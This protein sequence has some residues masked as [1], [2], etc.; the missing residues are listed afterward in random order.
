MYISFHLVIVGTTPTLTSESVFLTQPIN[1]TLKADDTFQAFIIT[2]SSSVSVWMEMGNCHLFHSME[3]SCDNLD[4]VGNDSCN[5]ESDVCTILFNIRLNNDTLTQ[6]VNSSEPYLIRVSFVH[7]HIKT[8]A[9]NFTAYIH[10]VRSNPPDMINH[11]CSDPCPDV[12]STPPDVATYNCTDPQSPDLVCYC[13]NS[14]KHSSGF[15]FCNVYNSWL[16][17]SVSVIL[18]VVL[19]F[20]V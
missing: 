10:V 12:T 11:N 5:R 17:V 16:L 3:S 15:Q 20:S 18:N 9:S 6:L 14:G 8:I 13:N 2:N 7:K 19:S 4:F 1:V